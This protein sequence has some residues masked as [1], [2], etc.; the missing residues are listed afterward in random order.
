[1]KNYTY[2]IVLRYG[3]YREIE[4]KKI[5]NVRVLNKTYTHTKPGKAGFVNTAWS[6]TQQRGTEYILGLFSV[7]FYKY[8][9]T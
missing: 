9:F 7:C 3:F 5:S 2:Y 1:M 8:N 6:S 4:K